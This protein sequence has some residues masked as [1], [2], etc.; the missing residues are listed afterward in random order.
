MKGSAAAATAMAAKGSAAVATATAATAP[1]PEGW[2]ACR[3]RTCVLA[4]PF[5]LEALSGVQKLERERDLGSAEVKQL[6]GAARAR[7][8]VAIGHRGCRRRRRRRRIAVKENELNGTPGRIA[9]YLP[10]ILHRVK[11]LREVLLALGGVPVP[12]LDQL[13]AVADDRDGKAGVDGRGDS[14]DDPVG[15]AYGGNFVTRPAS[16]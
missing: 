2:L 13:T 16:V 3:S 9:A 11:V 15:H 5:D 4:H 10:V 12:E 7:V 8:G 14:T 1:L 6:F